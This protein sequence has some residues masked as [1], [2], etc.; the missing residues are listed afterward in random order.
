MSHYGRGRGDKRTMK[1]LLLHLRVI[2]QSEPIP[3]FT[4]SVALFIGKVDGVDMIELRLGDTTMKRCVV[5]KGCKGRKS[6]HLE[7]TL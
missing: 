3:Q 1:R 5:H 4:S 2:S 7:A 6:Q